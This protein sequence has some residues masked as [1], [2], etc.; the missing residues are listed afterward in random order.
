VVLF[1]G[2]VGITYSNLFSYSA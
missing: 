1:A 2:P